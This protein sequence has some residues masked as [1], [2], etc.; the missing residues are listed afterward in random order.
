MGQKAWIHLWIHLLLQFFTP[1]TELLSI[2]EALGMAHPH[3]FKGNY[4]QSLSPKFL[5]LAQRLQHSCISYPCVT[6]LPPRSSLGSVLALTMH[7]EN[8]RL[9]VSVG[10]LWTT[11]SLVANLHHEFKPYNN[12][13]PRKGQLCRNWK[14]STFGIFS[15]YNPEI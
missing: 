13:F 4:N 1:S 3:S 12:V 5:S 11:A 7:T 9:G 6:S 8:S 14:I 2:R 10:R 15:G